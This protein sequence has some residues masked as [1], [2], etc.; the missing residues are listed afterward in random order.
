MNNTQF[1]QLMSVLESIKLAVGGECGDKNPKYIVSRT[2]TLASITESKQLDFLEVPY[3]HKV[4]FLAPASN[5]G[6]IYLATNA[7]DALD[8]THS[9]PLAAGKTV[10]YEIENVG[11]VWACPATANDT[12]LWTVEQWG[13][14]WR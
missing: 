9:Y 11:K 5:S 1:T 7:V 6:I 12:L 10:E 3:E 4:Q 8:I 2:I 13:E 14:N